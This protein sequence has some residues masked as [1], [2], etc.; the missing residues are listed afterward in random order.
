MLQLD[1]EVMVL[2]G[3]AYQK[4]G[5]G[6]CRLVD[7]SEQV[8]FAVTASLPA[9][10]AHLHPTVLSSNAP[11]RYMGGSS[12]PLPLRGFPCG[13]ITPCAVHAL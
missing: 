3:V 5:E 10:L 8:G 4:G 12:P 7:P 11:A 13:A 6:K 1:G 9:L 2:D